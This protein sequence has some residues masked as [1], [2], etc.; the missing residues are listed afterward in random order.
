MRAASFTRAGTYRLVLTVRDADGMSATSAVDVEV[1]Q[2]ATTLALSPSTAAIAVDGGLRLAAAMRDQF[3]DAMPADVAWSVDA[4]G[5][6]D[7]DGWFSAGSAPGGP[8]AVTARADGRTASALINVID[9]I[10]LRVT[11]QPPGT[12]PW[13]DWLVDDGAEFAD[14]GNGQA[15]GWNQA[16]RESRARQSGNAP[17]ARYDRC[18]YLQKPSLRDARW[19]IAL[20]VGRYRVRVVCGDPLYTNARYR[21][22]VEDEVLLDGEPD[23][24][25]PWIDASGEV[26][27]VDGRLTVS[28]ADGAKGNR[29][30]FIEIAALPAGDG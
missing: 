16:N 30:A 23:A 9:G 1:A 5:A 7:A 28:N 21:I 10:A 4:A 11:F 2:T 17:D 20:P 14:R 24:A 18:L 29:I 12:P 15:Y 22:A 26:E 13:Q 3:A 25:H 19:E 6:I 27:V 8:I